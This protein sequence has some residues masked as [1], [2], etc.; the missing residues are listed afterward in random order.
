MWITRWSY[1]VPR[2]WMHNYDIKNKYD[3][4][5]KDCMVEK[6]VPIP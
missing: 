4:T 5:L 2:H 6:H 3:K 1:L